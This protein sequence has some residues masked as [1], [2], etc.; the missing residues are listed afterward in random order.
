MGIALSF[1]ALSRIVAGESARAAGPK[2][3]AEEI[4]RSAGIE[5]GLCVHLG[6]GDGRLTAEL[7]R[8]RNLVVHGLSPD[9]KAVAK[10]RRYLE[11]QGLYGQASVDYAALSRLPYADHLVNLVVADGLPRLMDA[12]LSLKAVMR[13]LRPNGAAYLGQAAGNESALAR[14]LR[15]AGVEEFTIVARNGVWARVRKPRPASMDE[16][17]HRTYD[18]SGNCV[19]HDTAIGPLATL[20]WIAGPAWPMGTGYQV[21]NGGLLSAGGRVFSVT[22]NEVSN[23]KRVPQ[24]RN[25]AWFLTARDAYNGLL[26]WSRP[27][28][29]KMLRDGQELGNAVVAAGDR[30]YAVLGRSLVALNAATGKT[31]TTCLTDVLPNTK[32]AWRHGTLVVAGPKWVRAIDLAAGK[33]RWQR[34]ANAQDL[35]VGEGQ[36]F[37]TTDRQAALV[38]LDLEAGRQR[39]RV[40]LGAYKGRKKQLLFAKAGIVVFVWERNWQIGHNG[41]AAFSATDGKRVWSFEYKSA[42]ATWPNTVWFVDGLVWHRKGRAG[43]AG[44]DPLTGEMKRSIVMKGGYC[45]GCTR[46]IATERYLVSTRPLNFFDWTDGRVHGFRAGRHPCRAGVIVANGLLYSQ[47]HGC[48]CVKESLRGFLAFAP[49]G[50]PVQKEAERLERG[51]AA[52]IELTEPSAAADEE[53]PTFRHDPQRTCGTASKL[54]GDLK[55]LWEVEVDDQQ[56][57]GSPVAD[58]WLAHPLGGD[59]LTASVVAGGMVFAALPDAHRVVAL[60]ARTG[61]RRWSYTA[62]G[63]LDTPPTIHR[64]L[65]LF[66]CYDGRVYCLRASDGA[67]VWR[68]RAAPGQRRIV[69]FGQVESSWPVVGGVLVENDRAYFVAGRSSALEEGIRGYAVDPRSGK[70]AWTKPLAGAVS[71]IL[72]SEGGALRLAGGASAGI[73]FDAHTG[74]RLRGGLSPGFRWTYSG[75][76][77]TWWGGP[78]RV[79]DR[80]WRALSVNDTASHWMKIKQG[81]GPHHGQLLVASPDR[82]KTFA[83]RFKYVHW[84]KVKD[85]RT[86]FGGELVAWEGGKRRWLVEVPKTFQ[87][88]AMVLAGDVLFAAGPRGRFRRKGGKLWALSARDGKT[89]REYELDAPPAAEGMA[90]AAGRLYLSTQGGRVLCFGQK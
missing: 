6:C 42:R 61:R 12:G 70:I 71:D 66:G 73:R 86:E 20:R 77:T 9:R 60:D 36:V 30:L 51:P 81:Y 46:D 83:F 17:T 5:A 31:V 23:L 47:P 53:W 63:R 62:G 79:L 13:V 56:M 74:K 10:A 37:F 33:L 82:K 2:A 90:A 65:C 8:G 22:L 58:E 52:G 28:N 27:I 50:A 38:C 45:G 32:L 21:S 67:L 34:A 87:V 26:L 43:L 85:S 76:I 41:I 54:P 18:A 19:S 89:L 16:W 55:L 78:N 75:K 39:W 35:V 15:A 25:N 88:E 68:L 29:R 40:D 49:A 3:L 14:V 24:E 1:A 48:K 80:T 7:A 84:S 11:S 59:R 64:G 44:L 69:A 57:P 72:V 4:L